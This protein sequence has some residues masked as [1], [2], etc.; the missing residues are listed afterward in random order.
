MY[1]ANT[2]SI[3]QSITFLLLYKTFKHKM[4]NLKHIR[5]IHSDIFHVN[6]VKV[7]RNI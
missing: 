4:E 7:V 3:S 6:W 5:V 2:R 1:M